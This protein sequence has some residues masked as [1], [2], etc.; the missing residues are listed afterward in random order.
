MPQ[1]KILIINNLNFSYREN[2]IEFS[3][4]KLENNKKSL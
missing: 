3:T 1:K 2:I 4:T